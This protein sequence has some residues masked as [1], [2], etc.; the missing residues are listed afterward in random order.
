M[1]NPET[2]DSPQ[3][4]FFRECG[5]DS[6]RTGDLG[7]IANILHKDFRYLAYPRSLGQP[8]QTKEEWLE[9]WTGIMSLWTTGLDVSY[10]GA[11]QIAFAAT[12]SLPQLTF[13]F[14]RGNSGKSRRSR[15]YL[16]RLDPPH[17]LM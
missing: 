17:L 11:T 10:I 8:E 1:A 14:H 9:R 3:L 5:Q 13:R 2:S 16:K 15:S 7:S 6:K 4:K 12:K